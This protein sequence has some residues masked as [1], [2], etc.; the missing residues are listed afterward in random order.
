MR[1][2]RIYRKIVFFAMRLLFSVWGIKKCYEGCCCCC[3]RSNCCELRVSGS[4]PHAPCFVLVVFIVV[5]V[6][7]LSAYR[8]L[9]RK[10]AAQM[11]K[12]YLFNS[13]VE[14]CYLL[15]LHI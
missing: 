3:N 11:Y 12:Y 4:M 2:I 6:V 14:A 9:M 10:P 5:M 7:G 8:S 15:R 13:V 1:S